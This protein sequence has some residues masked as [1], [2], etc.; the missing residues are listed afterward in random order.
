MTTSDSSTLFTHCHIQHSKKLST[1]NYPKDAET[2]TVDPIL[3]ALFITP[4]IQTKSGLAFIQSQAMPDITALRRDILTQYVYL[5]YF[6]ESCCMWFRFF[7]LQLSAYAP[8]NHRTCPSQTAVPTCF[9]P[10]AWRRVLTEWAFLHSLILRINYVHCV[11]RPTEPLSRCPLF[12]I[13]AVIH[14]RMWSICYGSWTIM[15]MLRC[16]SS[17]IS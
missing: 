17:F 5:P 13:D 6:N 8:R 12:W 16:Y 15:T 1:T 4:I 9:A 14:R 7:W 3:Y 11:T 10:R 2:H